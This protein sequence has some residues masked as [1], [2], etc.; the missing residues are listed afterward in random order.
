M[1]AE[2]SSR[3]WMDGTPLT[4]GGTDR[5]G[6]CSRPS[7][8]E[9]K[10]ER[11]I[12]WSFA[13]NGAM[14]PGQGNISLFRLSFCRFSEIMRFGG[15]SMFPCAG[16]ESSNLKAEAKALDGSGYCACEAVDIVEGLR[17]VRRVGIG[18]DVT[19]SY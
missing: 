5:S 14:T 15:L 1:N 16:V 19:V 2:V 11:E 9:G 10:L 18:M 8:C 12:R 17:L 6:S 4:E 3:R 13:A 7:S